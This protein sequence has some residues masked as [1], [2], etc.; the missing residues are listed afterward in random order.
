M[1]ENQLGVIAYG[2]DRRSIE[3]NDSL[4]KQCYNLGLRVVETARI[5]K[6]GTFAIA[7][8]LP[9][10]YFYSRLAMGAVSRPQGEVL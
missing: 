6:M 2:S 7:E 10:A 8:V 5:V 4:L 3:E 1:P 9:E